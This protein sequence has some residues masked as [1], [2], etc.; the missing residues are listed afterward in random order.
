M[1]TKL[2]IQR[3]G[4]LKKAGIFSAGTISAGAAQTILSPSNANAQ[5]NEGSEWPFPFVFLDPD[6]AAQR[7]YEAFYQGACCYG[8]VQGILSQWKEMLGEP[9]STLP[10][11]M[12]KYG[13]GGIVGWGSVCGTLNGASAMINLVCESEDAAP[14]INELVAWYSSTAVPVFIPAENTAIE[15]STSN[16]PLCHASVGRWCKVAGV[17]VTSPERKERCARLVADVA[18]K[19]STLLNDHFQ[20]EFVSQHSPAASV[21]ECNVCHGP[22]AQNNSLGKMDCVSC[23]EPGNHPL[24]VSSWD[25]Y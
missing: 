17:G 16:S 7:G 20:N 9:F 3:R 15:V 6:L 25:K 14:L 23:H 10:A 12:F 13:E 21:A 22:S 11:E 18:S 1:N 5:I 4:F 2:T 19:A 8:T 24:P